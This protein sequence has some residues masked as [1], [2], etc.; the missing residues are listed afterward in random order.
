MGTEIV[1]TIASV[2]LVPDFVALS[3]THYQDGPV[4]DPDFVCWR[5]LEA[6]TG[7][8]IA[9]EL[10]DGSDRVGRMWILKQRWNVHGKI[11]AAANPVDFLIREDHRRLPS[12]LSLFKGTMKEAHRN[13]DVVYHTSN[14][15]TDNLYRKLMK[16]EPV[17]E[18]DGALLPVRPFAVARTTGV[19][20]LG[21]AGTL[22]DGFFRVGV[23]LVGRASRC[24]RV[25]LAPNASVDEAEAIAVSL[26]AEESVC[27]ARIAEDVA[28]RYRGAGSIAYKRCWIRRH[29]RVVGS[30]VTTDRQVNGL[31]GRFVVDVVWPGRP[32]R[33]AIRAMWAQVGAE[34]AADEIDAVFF[35]ANRANPRL[36]RL[37]AW[38]MVAV[39]RDRLPQRVPVFVRLSSD[40]DGNEVSET[41]WSSAYLV[42][43]DFDM[44]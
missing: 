16:Y 22:L 42:L 35:L 11:R 15:L 31:R 29:G 7:P 6:P 34:G 41:D 39:G 21:I 26:R 38:P 44:F 43:G 12:F 28:W 10:V 5:H 9:V 8:S 27:N 18:L 32:P 3:S 36:A 23:W 13:A 1:A 4:T 33:R 19:L 2:D 25:T 17:T 30:V 14:P 40:P 24:L 20:N 37:T